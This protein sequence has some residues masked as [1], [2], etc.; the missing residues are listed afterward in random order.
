M[1]AEKKEGLEEQFLRDKKESGK[2]VRIY[3]QNGV[4]LDGRIIDFD[5]SVI[6]LETGRR[7]LVYKNAITTIS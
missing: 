1:Q 4:P 3:L 7:L 5:N 6:I 2:P